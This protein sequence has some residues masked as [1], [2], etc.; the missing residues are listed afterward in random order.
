[1]DVLEHVPKPQRQSFCDELRRVAS[2][3]VLLHAPVQSDVGTFRA[4]EFDQSFYQWFRKTYGR[5]EVNTQQHLENGHPSPQELE[6][7]FPG[8]SI[9]GTQNAEDWYRRV[10]HIRRPL[11]AV[12]LALRSALRGGSPG[13]PYYSALLVWRQSS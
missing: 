7:Y 13:P 6:A 5:E 3:G 11:G 10:L 1:M 8:S 9:M 12:A 4:M 2:R